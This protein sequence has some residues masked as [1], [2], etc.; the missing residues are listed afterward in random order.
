MED[1]TPGLLEEIRADFT[2]R[3]SLDAKIRAVYQK[4]L[5]GGATYA[6]AEDYAY[7]VGKALSQAF[8][9]I[10][11]SEILPD[12]KLYFNIADRVFRPM[13]EEDH[14]VVSSAAVMVQT[15]LNEKSGIGIKPQTVPVNAERIS[16]IV[17]KVSNAENFEDVAWVL[18]E[19]VKNFS[20]NVVDETIR[21]NVEFQGKA[22]LSPRIIRKAEGKCCSWCANLEGV[23]DYPDLPDDVYRRHERCRC[24]VEYDPGDGRRQNV[25]T[26]KWT[27]PGERD[28]IEVRKTVGV[29]TLPQELADKPARLASYTPQSLLDELKNAGFEV[30]P[31]KQG[32]L[33][34]IL[35][36]D[37][38][39]FKVN[40]ND[41]GILQYHPE[42]GS[43]HDGA[44]Y[45]ISTGKGG[46]HRYGLDGK[47]K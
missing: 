12:S 28:K 6:D 39:G 31:L 14:S 18:D 8:G 21:E 43:H 38:G 32:S 7:Q 13:L 10:L 41:G 20:M 11:T 3:I 27:E 2:Q 46:K 42:K 22:G 34:D 36:E 17:D 5:G 35:Y 29:K 4:I 16:G 15:F 9:K 45:K 47:E 33:K 19:P 40:F 44:Y 26:K 1:I 23:Y 30:K 24:V 37:G 25:H